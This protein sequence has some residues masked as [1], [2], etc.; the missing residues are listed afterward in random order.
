MVTRYVLFGNKLATTVTARGHNT[1]IEH[2]YVGEQVVRNLRASVHVD[3]V[4]VAVPH[5]VCG[6]PDA[7]TQ[8]HAL[9]VHNTRQ[10]SLLVVGTESGGVHVRALY[11]GGIEH[12]VASVSHLGLQSFQ[13]YLHL[14][15]SVPNLEQVGHGTRTGGL[16]LGSVHVEHHVLGLQVHGLCLQQSVAYQIFP[17]LVVVTL[18]QVEVSIDASTLYVY[19]DVWELSEFHSRVVGVYYVANEQVGLFLH[20]NDVESLLQLD[21]VALYTAQLHRLCLEGSIG[22][23]VAIHEQQKGILGVSRNTRRIGKVAKLIT[24]AHLPCPVVVVGVGLVGSDAETLFPVI[25]TGIGCPCL[26]FNLQ[27]DILQNNRNAIVLHL[28]L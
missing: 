18:G 1:L 9:V 11:A 26:V 8:A 7:A 20:G 28:C 4:L 22:W 21:A 6:S 3:E 15:N 14:H 23:H 24:H 5:F 27:H 10:C 2:G 19:F 13:V 25:T 17:Y 16:Y 12:I